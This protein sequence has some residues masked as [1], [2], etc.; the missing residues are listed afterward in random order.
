[1]N[2]LKILNF[3][4]I[5]GGY[6]RNNGFM[7]FNQ[8]TLFCGTQGTGKS[9]VAKLYS[10]FVW[11]EKALLRGDFKV[12]DLERGKIFITRYLKF[13]NIDGAEQSDDITIMCLHYKQL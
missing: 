4:P 3:G 5:I 12:T 10:T 8:I 2:Q 11:L 1:M 7:N 13:Q 9:T 6:D